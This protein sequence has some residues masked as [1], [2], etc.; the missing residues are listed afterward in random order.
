M[1]RSPGRPLLEHTVRQ[2][3]AYGVRDLAINLHRH[4]DVIRHHFGDGHEYACG[5]IIPRNRTCSEPPAV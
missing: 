4:G 1:S 2:L 3:A 5:S